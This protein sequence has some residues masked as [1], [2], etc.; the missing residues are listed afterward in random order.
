MFIERRIN[1]STSVIELWE[2][3]WKNDGASPAHKVYLKKLALNNRLKTQKLIII[4]NQK[5]YAGHMIAPSETLQC[6]LSL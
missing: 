2:C 6:F 5:L 4:A 1:P 3:Q